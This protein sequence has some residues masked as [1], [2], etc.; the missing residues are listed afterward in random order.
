VS[1]WPG[2]A[3]LDG[4]SGRYPAI[5][6]QASVRSRPPAETQANALHNECQPLPIAPSLRGAVR[7]RSSFP[8]AAGP[9]GFRDPLDQGDAAPA[10]DGLL[11]TCQTAKKFA[12]SK[13]FIWEMSDKVPPPFGH[14]RLRLA[15]EWGDT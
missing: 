11:V 8:F 7:P 15:D 4:N 14:G 6:R 1:P 13:G 2:R 10:A 3:E 5:D 9:L 12:K